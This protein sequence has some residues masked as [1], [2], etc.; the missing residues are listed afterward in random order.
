MRVWNWLRRYAVIL[1]VVASGLLV[2]PQAR[3][4]TPTSQRSK[5]E[6]RVAILPVLVW[7]H[8]YAL[9]GLPPK[10]WLTLDQLPEFLRQRRE[11]EDELTLE[12]EAAYAEVCAGTVGLL[13]AA[14]L[15]VTAAAKMAAALTQYVPDFWDVDGRAPHALAD[16]AA[17]TDVQ[18][19]LLVELLPTEGFLRH[20]FGDWLSYQAAAPE[21]VRTPVR[22]EVF[23]RDGRSEIAAAVVSD[24]KRA[25][26]SEG[27]R[28]AVWQALSPW[29]GIA[30]EIPAPDLG[31][32]AAGTAPP[33]E[34]VFGR[35]AEPQS[36]A[37]PRDGKVGITVFCTNPDHH[38]YVPK[39]T[40][41]LPGRLFDYSK[42][43]GLP[44]VTIPSPIAGS[45]KG[46]ETLRASQFRAAD[47]LVEIGRASGVAVVLAVDVIGAFARQT[48]HSSTGP[49]YVVLAT[50]VDVATGQTVKTLALS[51]E[52]GPSIEEQVFSILSVE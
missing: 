18:H 13:S 49:Q 52:E 44:S 1:A 28:K 33:F 2:V 31:S 42:R 47:R 15:E 3:A 43:R 35:F 11:R 38:G 19:V 51:E 50:A 39:F 48:K 32:S 8:P 17:A 10:G 40:D 46:E 5:V 41:R 26:Q 36:V 14:G 4:S 16:L 21:I 24:A 12:Q 45:R 7:Q 34:Y 37:V 9:S 20:T 30:G 22:V 27:W 6:G 29:L 25:V 23:D